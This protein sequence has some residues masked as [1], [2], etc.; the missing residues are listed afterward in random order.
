M[1][2]RLIL[3]RHSLPEITSDV[4]ARQWKL[5]EEGKARAARLAKCLISYRPASL[6]SSPEQKAAETAE[7]LSKKFF[8][9]VDVMQDLQEHKRSLISFLSETEFR[10]A[11]QSF[12]EKPDLQVFGDETANEAYERFS[13]AVLSAFSENP[14][15]PT[16][17]VSHGT[18]MSLFVSRVTGQPAFDIWRGLGLPGFLVLDMQTNQLVSSENFS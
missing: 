16:V 15:E 8:L 14:S 7:I 2:A 17:I 3:V 12:F 10:A 1:S 5:S 9:P 11:I 13:K 6:F 18:V 4:P